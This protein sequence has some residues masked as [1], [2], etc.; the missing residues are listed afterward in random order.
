MLWDKNGLLGLCLSRI[1]LPAS[2]VRGW[3]PLVPPH[4][5]ERLIITILRLLHDWVMSLPTLL[6]YQCIQEIHW[7]GVTL[8]CLSSF[9]MHIKHQVSCAVFE[10]QHISC[11]VLKLSTRSTLPTQSGLYSEHHWPLGTPWDAGWG[12][13]CNQKARE[14][15]NSLFRPLC[16]FRSCW[17][18]CSS[19][20]QCSKSW[21]PPRWGLAS[22]L[23]LCVTWLWPVLW[24][25]WRA[26]CV[27]LDIL[28]Q[29]PWACSCTA[30]AD[31]TPLA[32]LAAEVSI[33]NVRNGGEGFLLERCLTQGP[34][35]LLDVGAAEEPEVCFVLLMSQG[36]NACRN[37]CASRSMSV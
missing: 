35:V 20:S 8:Q 4:H 28:H 1:W 16:L 25:G 33:G 13:I 30:L 15:K 3:S 14:E 37:K 21:E 36:I 26:G 29:H 22:C 34:I 6:Q 11:A 9:F 5:R 10:V 32:T 27:L 23:E 12:E 24:A 17:L 18:P 2:L 19:S 31:G 7:Q